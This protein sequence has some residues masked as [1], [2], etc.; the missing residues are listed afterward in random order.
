MRLNHLFLFILVFLSSC[1]HQSNS[2]KKGNAEIKKLNKTWIVNSISYDAGVADSLK[3][4]EVSFELYFGDCNYQDNAPS[5]FC[6]GQYVFDSVPRGLIYQ[7]QFESNQF[8]L[9]FGNDATSLSQPVTP[10]KSQAIAIQKLINLLNG[11]WTIV[12]NGETL[13]GEMK[14]SIIN[15]GGL[16]KF[17]AK[18]K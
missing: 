11:N 2:E 16:V 3:L 9:R 4:P 12:A 13:T 5:L 7:Y 17:T 15:N 8:S 1:E 6:D 10:T 14:S 18:R